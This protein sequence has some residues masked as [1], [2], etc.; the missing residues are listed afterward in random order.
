VI[1]EVHSGVQYIGERK[2]LIQ[3]KESGSQ[4]WISIEVREQKKLDIVE[5]RDFRRE[6]LPEK[7]IMKM[8]YR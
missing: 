3:C 6:E 7:Y 4:V 5:E 2:R 1:E 8:L